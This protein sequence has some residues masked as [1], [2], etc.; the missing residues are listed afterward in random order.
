MRKTE[1]PCEKKDFCNLQDL[2]E[3]RGQKRPL[4]QKVRIWSNER[5]NQDPRLTP[6]KASNP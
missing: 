1:S 5:K 3:N 6:A 4:G 2:R